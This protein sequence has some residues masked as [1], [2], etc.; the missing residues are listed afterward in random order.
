MNKLSEQSL[1]RNFV[2]TPLIDFTTKLGRSIGL[3]SQRK[4]ALG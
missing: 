2:A 3:I 4:P 1:N